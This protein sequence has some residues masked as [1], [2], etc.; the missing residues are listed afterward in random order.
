MTSFPPFPITYD[1]LSS[2]YIS[3]STLFIIKN[4]SHIKM[5]NN[6]GPNMGPWETPKGI[7]SHELYAVLIFAL[8]FLLDN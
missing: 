7:S 2:A 8:C 1:V 4:K 6:R 5:L 3:K